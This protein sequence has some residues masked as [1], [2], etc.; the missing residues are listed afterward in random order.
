MNEINRQST[1]KYK[2]NFQVE[3]IYHIWIKHECFCCANTERM[4]KKGEE[5]EEGN[6]YI[7]KSTRVSYADRCLS[8]FHSF[9][10]K[11][12]DENCFT[13]KHFIFWSILSCHID[14]YTIYIIIF[15]FSFFFILSFLPLTFLFFRAYCDNISYYIF[16]Y[17]LSLFAS[18]FIL[19]FFP[20]FHL[21][22][23]GF[24]YTHC[25]TLPAS[26]F[27]VRIICVISYRVLDICS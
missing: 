13:Q 25:S 3:A 26:V 18:L 22:G 4:K 24:V 19:F 9:R 14:L 11:K 2:H 21:F 12:E 27:S 6:Y 23:F 15:F 8:F 1:H 20:H 10:R 17:S 5:E 16:P 7:P